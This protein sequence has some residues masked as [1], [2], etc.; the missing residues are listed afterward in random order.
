MRI[1]FTSLFLLGLA[2]P[3]YAQDATAEP[4]MVDSKVTGAATETFTPKVETLKQGFGSYYQNKGQPRVTVYWNKN[5]D[6]R[7][8]E[9]ETPAARINQSTDYTGTIDGPDGQ[10]DIALGATTTTEV[11]RRV[12]QR[13]VF[14]H[15]SDDMTR[16][17]EKGFKKTLLNA[18]VKLTDQT[19]IMRLASHKDAVNRGQ[20]ASQDRF[21][22]EIDALKEHTDWLFEITSTPDRKSPWGSEFAVK[23]L[24]LKTGQVLAQAE[25]NGTDDKK[26]GQFEGPWGTDN[27]GYSQDAGVGKD[28]LI[29]ESQTIWNADGHGYGEASALKTPEKIGESLAYHLFENLVN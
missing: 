11:Q 3:T 15:L 1:L 29:A 17:I 23:L 26:Y 13:V 9:W 27:G 4:M 28:T 14:S 12:S 20:N 16:G 6:D 21:F 7:L 2:F 8:S 5:L 10:Q 22:I 18:K 25:L 19:A 24:D